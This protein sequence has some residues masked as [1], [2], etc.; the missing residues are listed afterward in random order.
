MLL[1]LLFRL[2]STGPPTAPWRLLLETSQSAPPRAQSNRAAVRAATAGQLKKKEAGTGPTFSFRKGQGK[3]ESRT[4]C[5]AT[6]EKRQTFHR[7][8]RKS[9]FV[10]RLPYMEFSLIDV[11][12]MI[13][14]PPTKHKTFFW[15]HL[16]YILLYSRLFSLAACN[17]LGGGARAAHCS[18]M[19]MMMVARLL[20]RPSGRRLCN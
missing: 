18:D 3:I 14:W 16:I 10:N 7:G 4:S 17:Y 13:P 1:A 12:L 9:P 5:E 2:Q 8:R 19:P 6:Q 15:L 11:T 20:I